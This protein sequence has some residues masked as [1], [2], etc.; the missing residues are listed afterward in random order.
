MDIINTKK[1]K[2]VP[3]PQTKQVKR[4]PLLQKKF[5]NNPIQK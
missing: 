3:R 2:K 1:G 4:S 5:E